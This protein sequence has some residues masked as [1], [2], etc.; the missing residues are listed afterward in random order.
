MRITIELDTAELTE[1]D[2]T[3]LRALGGG[4]TAPMFDFIQGGGKG[5]N[6][7]PATG[8]AHPDEK[9]DLGEPSPEKEE[10]AAEPTP[11]RR[12]RKKA[13]PEPETAAPEPEQAETVQ[14]AQ[15]EPEAVSEA[16][17]APSEDSPSVIEKFRA[18]A[19][20]KAAE[21]LQAGDKAKVLAALEQVGARKVSQ[22]ADDKLAAFMGA[23]Q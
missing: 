4:S 22:V 9:I 6:W 20:A 2:R 5:G 16:P 12:T 14:P 19:V 18:E 10:P 1:T 21:L 17:E 23:L 15:E 13:A 7:R 11:K 3:M 8:A